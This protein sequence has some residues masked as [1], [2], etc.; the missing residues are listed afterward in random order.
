MSEW[1]SYQQI[2]EGGGSLRLDKELCLWLPGVQTAPV[3]REA[4][5]AFAH[6]ILFYF[7]CRES[8]EQELKKLKSLSWRC[9]TYGNIQFDKCEHFRAHIRELEG[10]LTTDGG[11]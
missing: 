7:Q 10:T 9:C 11:A 6:D 8:D 4:L 3:A 2:E 5:I 1:I